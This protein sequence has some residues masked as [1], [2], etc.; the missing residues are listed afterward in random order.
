MS[1]ADPS[2]TQTCAE[3]PATAER[4]TRSQLLGQSIGITGTPTFFINGRRIG[5]PSVAQYEALEA[6]VAFEAAQAAEEK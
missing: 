4:I 1:G 2:A 3:S 6:V 5:N